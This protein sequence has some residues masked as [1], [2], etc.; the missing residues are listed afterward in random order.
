MASLLP[1]SKSTHNNKT[2]PSLESLFA[3]DNNHHSH[4]KPQRK[5]RSRSIDR[6]AHSGELYRALSHP[7][8]PASSDVHISHGTPFGRSLKASPFASH[9]YVPPT[10]AP[11]YKGE[12]YNWDRGF[13]AELEREI[14]GGDDAKTTGNGN[15][16]EEEQDAQ[17]LVGIE[18]LAAHARAKAKARDS[19]DLGY[20][21]ERKSGGVELFGRK[22]STTPV[23]SPA[24]G[25]M[26]R[27]RFE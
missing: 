13:S 17:E 22:L 10:G 2:T 26:V 21:M 25:D 9:V 14:G 23:L 8:P 15:G 19:L 1:S 7:T 16:G 5:S 27:L 4:H 3:I 24:L 12:Q 11:G 18:V 20:L 6:R